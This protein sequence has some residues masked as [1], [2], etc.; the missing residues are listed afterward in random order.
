MSARQEVSTRQRSV[1]DIHEWGAN[2]TVYAPFKT[3]LT[4]MAY[5]NYHEFRP[6]SRML[7]GFTPLP[8]DQ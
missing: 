1:T 6:T 3:I 5:D 2:F 7:P 8:G 4:D